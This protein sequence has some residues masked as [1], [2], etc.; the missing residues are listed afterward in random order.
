MGGYFSHEALC[1]N[2]IQHE[3]LQCI[4]HPNMDAVVEIE[5]ERQRKDRLLR[6]RCYRHLSTANKR[7]QMQDIKFYMRRNFDAIHNF[8]INQDQW[9]HFLQKHQRKQRKCL[10]MMQERLSK[11]AQDELQTEFNISQWVW[12]AQ[13]TVI[14]KTQVNQRI[15][16][17]TCR[18]QPHAAPKNLLQT[19]A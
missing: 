18:Q 17:S 13:K 16:Q 14:S 19:V 1:P 5:E 12:K 2:H 9:Q 6:F 10:L 4:R 15:P 7:L 8:V 3:I 11:K